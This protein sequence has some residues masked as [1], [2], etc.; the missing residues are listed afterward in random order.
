MLLGGLHP[1]TRSF[2]E[3]LITFTMLEELSWAT[4]CMEARWEEVLSSRYILKTE[5]TELTERH[6]EI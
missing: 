4:R 3:Y 1:F 2:M 5:Q 6:D